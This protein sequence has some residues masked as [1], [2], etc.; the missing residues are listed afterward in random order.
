MY[1]SSPSY[2]SIGS[3]SFI[4]PCI[5]ICVPSMA[6]SSRIFSPIFSY[7]SV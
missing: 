5:R 3:R 6:T 2:H 7:V 4:P 1:R